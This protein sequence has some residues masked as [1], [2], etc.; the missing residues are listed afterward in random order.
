MKNYKVL[1]CVMSYEITKG[2]KSRGPLGL[3]KKNNNTDELILKQIDYLT[4]SFTN[5][6]TY[7]VTGFGADKMHR[8]IPDYVSILSNDKFQEANQAYAFKLFVEAIKHRDDYSGIFILNAD[9]ILKNISIPDYDSSYIITKR[10]NKKLKEE[11]LLGAGLDH[12]NKLH[13]IFYNIGNL[14]WCNALYLCKKDLESLRTHINDYYDNMF[15]FEI[16]NKA[17][18]YHRIDIGFNMLQNNSDCIII[19]GLKDKYKII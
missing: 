3:L 13:T 16:I 7:I 11:Y 5:N 6:D 15:L 4:D 8:R 14:N 19:R 12:N 17:I 2:M 1:C 9:V 18:D 10:K